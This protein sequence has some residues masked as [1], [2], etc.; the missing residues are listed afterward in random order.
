MALSTHAQMTSITGTVTDSTNALVPLAKITAENMATG[1][2][3]TMETDESGTYRIT[4]LSPG[5]YDV[6]IEKAG[7]KSVVYSNVQLTVDQV[8]TLDAMLVP[9]SLNEKVTVNG[10]KVAPIDLTDAQISQAVESREIHDLPLLLRDPYQLVLL[11]PGAIQTNSLFQGFSVNGS[12]ERNNNF[13]LDGADNN[14]AEFAGFNVGFAAGQSRLNPDATQEFRVITNNYLPEFGRNT[15]AVVDIITRSGTNQFHTD[16]YWF[17]RY[18]ALGARDYFNHE[19]SS[20]GQTEPRNPYVRNDFGGSAGGPIL[21]KQLFWFVNYEGQRFVTTRTISTIVPNSAFATGVF[22]VTEQACVNAGNPVSA[23]T[24]TV[25]VSTPTSSSQIY[26]LPLDPVM[27]K[28][29]SL[30]PAPNGPALDSMRGIYFFPSKSDTTGDNVTA[31]ID[32][33]F[34]N[35][36]MLTARYIFNRLS[37]PNQY[38]TDFLPGL[39]TTG[40]LQRRQNLA[41]H[42]T[43]IIRQ[44]HTNELRFGA[45]RINFPLTCG[46]L[47]T[48]NSVGPT[49]LLSFGRGPDYDLPGLNGFGCMLLGDS[50]GSE[51]FSGTYTAGDTFAWVSGRH[52]VKTGLEFRDVYSNGFN[53]YA[54]RTLIDYSAFSNFGVPSFMTG[55]PYVN[56][57]VLLQNMVWSLFGIVD[58]ETQAQFFDKAGNRTANDMR[59]FRQHEFNGFVQDTYKIFSN[60]AVSYGFRY[61]FNGVPFE[62]NNLL[63]TLLVPPSGPAPFTFSIVGK[64]PGNLTLYQNDWK[65]VEPRISV[66][67]DPS[68]KG[69]TS[70]RTGYGI[71]HDRIFGQLIGLM[72][73]DPP[74]QQIFFEPLFTATG[75]GPPVSTLSSPP[76][77]TA[78]PVVNNEAGILPF[79]FDRNLRLPYSQNWNFGVQHEIVQSLLVEVNYVGTKGTALLRTVDGNPP[80]PN[81]VSRLEAF[82]VPGNPLNCDQSTLQFTNLWFGAESGLLPFDAVNNNAFYMAEV[83]DN[84]AFS[85]Y[86]A[87]QASFTQRLSHGV[88]IKGAYTFSHAIDDASDPLVPTQGNQSFPRDSFDLRGERG[89]SD[90]DVT[91]RLV[92]D[93]TWDLPYGPGHAHS[94]SGLVARIL[95]DWQLGGITTFSS[96][97]PFDIF[98][99]VDTAHTGQA[100]RPDYNPNGSPVPVRDIETQTGP[101]IGLF[102]IPAWGG[103]GDLGRNH[104]RGPGINDWDAV[105]T[106]R[107]Q[108]YDR[109]GLDIRMEFYN[110][111][112]RVQF[113]QPDNL[114]QDTGTFG[115]STSQVGRP[116]GTTGARQIQFGMKLR[117]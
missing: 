80:Q 98:T 111:F 16:I 112:N 34:S 53:D 86:Q 114:V 89:D 22:P 104:F 78:T 82:C 40:T 18:D 67:W 50:S 33:N 85:T 72:R 69:R 19:N 1:A 102:S 41:L 65:G 47:S 35:K 43:S 71:F 4:F 74:F 96:G 7:F 106:K 56:S 93:Y 42:L 94:G 55:N 27:H 107:F 77:L 17:G 23:C 6:R 92:M 13:M 63:S 12:R 116:D 108:I 64:G 37:D 49:E 44:T 29:F 115:Q 84:A 73:E 81:L 100:Q 20:T 117:F 58:E 88:S 90:L 2:V 32:H 25:D 87:L 11:S 68:H 66:A 75:I 101:N 70:I 79:L 5:A 97:L 10:E 60:L 31:R 91:Q 39:G 95:G 99:D 52:T 54:S 105:A 61:E 57:D 14:D 38:Y 83:Y 30:Y 3:R 8:Q 51:R 110:L 26:G 113:G 45:N 21:R 9:T 59:G 24:A 76:S 109:F 46:G 15:G 36:E 48:I 103:G 28:I 62:V